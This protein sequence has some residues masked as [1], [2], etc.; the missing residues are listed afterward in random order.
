MGISVIK[1][2]MT[3]LILAFLTGCTTTPNPYDRQKPEYLAPFGP[4]AESDPVIRH[5]EAGS[6]ASS[7]VEVGD[8]IIDIDGRPVSSTY[9]FYQMRLK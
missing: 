5:V 3:G 2:L 1:S 6:P 4:A 8:K 7:L 9:E